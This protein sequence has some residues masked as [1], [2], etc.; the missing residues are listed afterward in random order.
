MRDA[1]G[2]EPPLG[3]AA[4]F[5]KPVED[6]LGDVVGRYARSHGPFTDAEAA[7]A[8]GLQLRHHGRPVGS[9]TSTGAYHGH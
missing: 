7:E 2:V 3:I 1:I 4:D 8:T 6:P 9:R 5:L